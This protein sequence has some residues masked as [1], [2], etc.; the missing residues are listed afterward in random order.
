[1]KEST[2]HFE[3][4][5]GCRLFYQTWLPE[6]APR[7][8]VVLV[9]GVGE[10]CGRYGNMVDG[11]VAAGYAVAGYDHRGHGRSEGQRGHVEAF[12]DY[13]DDLGL[14]LKLVGG[15]LPGLPVFLYGHSMGSLI[16]LDYLL[17]D[18]A[19]LQGAI[20]SGTAL[21]PGDSASPLQVLLAKVLSGI[22]P[23][24]TI[25]MKLDGSTL[26]RDPEVARAYMEDPLDS[27]DRSARWGTE[28]LKAIAWLKGRAGDVRLPL[29][30]LHGE[31]D[32]IVR[33]A[34]AK[35]FYE[36]ITFPDK[37]IHIYPGG[38]HEPHNDIQH[39]EVLRDVLQWLDRHL[40][41]SQ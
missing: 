25:R 23:K 38:L 24:T 7:A 14:F 10:H 3:G 33:V 26:S 20:I 4:V 40:P 9:H 21:D 15:L 19:G 32:P 12:A 41:P 8:V 13:C 35:S 28:F 31:C 6:W 2:G 39:D 30:F 29:L 36:Q 16:A 27:W 37:E 17:R 22:A 18:P 34:G 11:L 1:V 5:R